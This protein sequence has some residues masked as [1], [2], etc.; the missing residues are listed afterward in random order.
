MIC[1]PKEKE[2]ASIIFSSSNLKTG[3]RNKF[4]CRDLTITE[5]DSHSLEIIP[6]K[7]HYGGES[8]FLCLFQS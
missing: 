3:Q 7:E 8:I 2:R 5:N 6:H 1:F 4:M